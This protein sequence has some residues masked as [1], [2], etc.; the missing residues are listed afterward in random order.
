[1][2]LAGRIFLALRVPIDLIMTRG[3]FVYPLSI[4]VPKL[5]HIIQNQNFKINM[6]Y[7]LGISDIFKHTVRSFVSVPNDIHV[8][9]T[10]NLILKTIVFYFC[11]GIFCIRSSSDRIPV[12]YI[13]QTNFMWYLWHDENV[14]EN[15]WYK[16]SWTFKSL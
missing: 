7:A 14:Y 5:Q 11:V 13:F 9:D 4:L 15:E 3:L 8:T 6:S 1:M 16:Y 12:V 2:N 10:T